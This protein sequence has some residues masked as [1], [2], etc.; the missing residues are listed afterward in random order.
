MFGKVGAWDH[1]NVAIKIGSK[2]SRNINGA[3]IQ[4][5]GERWGIEI[6]REVI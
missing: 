1:H 5:I 3:I 6:Y 4:F 2:I